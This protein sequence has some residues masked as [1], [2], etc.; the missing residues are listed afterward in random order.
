MIEDIGKKIAEDKITLGILTTG[1]LF[2]LLGIFNYFKI[3]FWDTFLTR[4]ISL[5]TPTIWIILA[6]V[7]FCSA[8]PAYFK[9]YNLVIIILLIALLGVTA[10]VR[11]S[12]LDGLKDV[13]TGTWTLGPD[14]DPFLYLRHANEIASGTLENPDMMRAAPIGAE[15]YAYKNLMPWAIIFI[16]KSV[17]LVHPVT[18]TYTAIIAPVI[19]FC[20]S[21]I[22]F[23]LFMYYLLQ[24]KFSKKKALITSFIAGVFYSIIP[25]MVGRT[26]AGDPEIESLGMVWFWLAFLFYVLAWK[27]DKTSYKIIF[28][29]LAGLF[30]GL[31]SYTWGG[32][33]FIYMI[34]SLIALILFLF[35]KEENKNFLIFSSWIIP[36]LILEFLKVEN[37]VHIITRVSDTGF[38]FIVLL[39]F[40]FN[41]GLSNG[42][43]KEKINKINIPKNILSII[44]VILA[45]MFFLLVFNRELLF[46]MVSKV[47]EGF[48]Y[49]WG[50]ERVGLTV[51][52]NRAPYFSEVLGEFGNLIWIFLLGTIF[53]FY[54]A[55]EHFKKQKETNFEKWIF[56]SIALFS[57][58]LLFYS[59][60]ALTS[61]DYSQ[62]KDQIDFLVLVSLTL[63]LVAGSYFI[64]KKESHLEINFAFLFLVGALIFSR[65]SPYSN[66]LNGENLFSKGIYFSGLIFFGGVILSNYIRAYR[67]KDE[68]T[69][70][71]FREINI[72]YL[73]VLVFSFW[74]IVS[75]RGA[76]RLFLIIS[77]MIIIS[78]SL[79]IAEVWALKKTLNKKL[80]FAGFLLLILIFAQIAIS[81]SLQ[82]QYTS[83]GMIPSIYHKQWQRS[84]QWVRDNTSE[85]SIFVHWWDYGYWVQTLGER[86]TV[87]DGGHAFEFWDH[88][89]GRY[90]LTAPTP[91]VA[92]SAIKTYN[93]THLLIDSS[94]IG[95][96][97]AFSK[98]G[99]NVGGEDRYSQIPIFVNDPKQTAETSNKT[100]K[101][102]AG[103]GFAD[104]DIIYLPE[105][106]NSKEIFLPKEKT[107]VVFI[108]SEIIKKNDSGIMEQP[109][110]VFIYNNQ[111]IQIP[112]RYLSYRGKTMDYKTGINATI[113]I[114]PKV[115]FVDNIQVQSDESGAIIYI[116]PKV[117]KSLFGQLYLLDSKEGRYSEFELVHSEP[118]QY[119][120][121][122]NSMGLNLKD[123]AYIGG[124]IRGPIKIWEVHPDENI[125]MNNEFL[126]TSG[127][128]AE[129]DNLT[130][131]KK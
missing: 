88:L 12:N 98:I 65:I 109:K 26:V 43:I 105:E 62:I 58:V 36:A 94:D 68:K 11:T 67:N 64:L 29:V 56:L 41:C 99:S 4:A 57:L 9:K 31:M 111:Q 39:F 28:G 121:Y 82:T 73:A 106:N 113:L 44:L 10:M 52:E 114:V 78:S 30:T 35:Q 74:A 112:I 33:R 72:L 124:D 61:G 32:Y 77:P 7:V 55:T 87:V 122:L 91:E 69:L 119:I 40:I 71:N 108:I 75:M 107:Y 19:F 92:L 86:A 63:P 24:F 85:N 16:Q 95:K 103:T 70:E 14:L 102:Y 120:D 23:F 79:F 1:F 80:F 130:F 81:Y 50:R 2:F 15:N 125:L 76:V 66:L 5:F 90:I 45:V 128:Y 8:I 13:T 115:T 34:I 27:K 84:M 118:D 104:E 117:T 18:I 17:S 129:F 38:A 25:S 100:I 123:F 46:N 53:I 42:K 127:E 49:P 54:K 89:M 83:K 131:V 116:S 3:S 37:I 20:A 126:R 6:L 101:V 21:I 93:A 51:A 22:G 97:P 110:A 48:L 59:G 96:Y 47:I 60:N